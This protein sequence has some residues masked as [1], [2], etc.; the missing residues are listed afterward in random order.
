MPQGFE[1]LSLRQITRRQTDHLTEINV[2]TSRLRLTA[3]ALVLCGIAACGSTAATSPSIV[4]LATPTALPPS[5]G[6]ALPS[7]S[8]TPTDCTFAASLGAPTSYAG[9]SVVT[10]ILTNN[11]SAPCVL[12]GYS[13]VQ[14]TNAGAAVG[15]VAETEGGG[16]A[17][18]ATPSAVSIAVGGTG[19]FIVEFA[20]VPSGAAPCPTVT[21]LSIELPSSAGSVSQPIATPL[22]PCPPTFN[23]GAVTS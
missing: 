20:D 23:V 15:S 12:N 5:S 3:L 10:V 4:A 18:T 6:A 17:A 22:Q 16:Q 7:P 21:Q 19:K 11:G 9:H 13:T 1:S 14:L 2:T 8:A